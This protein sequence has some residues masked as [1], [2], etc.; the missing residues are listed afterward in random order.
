LWTGERKGE[1]GEHQLFAFLTTQSNEIVRPIHA[2]AMPV[3]MTKPEEWDTW[4]DGSLEQARPARAERAVCLP[5]IPANFPI[6]AYQALTTQLSVSITLLLKAHKELIL[7]AGE[8]GLEP[9][10][11]GFGDRCSNQ[12]SYTPTLVSF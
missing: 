9:P 12:L 8:E 10:T 6:S 2:K 4:L 3:L 1:T 11:P 7:L 5:K